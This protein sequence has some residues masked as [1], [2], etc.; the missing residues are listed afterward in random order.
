MSREESSAALPT[1]TSV[2]PRARVIAVATY[3]ALSSVLGLGPGVILLLS[4]HDSPVVG[5]LNVWRAS[6]PSDA[7]FIGGSIAVALLT[8]GLAVRR[9]LLAVLCGYFLSI[10]VYAQAFFLILSVDQNHPDLSHYGAIITIVVEYGQLGLFFT[11]IA[12]ILW[13]LTTRQ[14][15]T[16]RTQTL[17]VPPEG[18]YR[19][20]DRSLRHEEARD[21]TVGPI[22]D[23]RL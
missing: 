3:V 14:S 18:F 23:W 19:L 4:E 2:S 11:A 1:S 22:G 8:F 5:F 9:P 17:S 20:Q 15:R 13:K 16:K 12:P 6:L 10:G 21:L 7:V